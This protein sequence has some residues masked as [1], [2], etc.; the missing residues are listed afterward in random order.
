MFKIG[1]IGAGTITQK[2]ITAYQDNPL[3]EVVSI[4]DINPEQAQKTA[5]EF[6]IKNVYTHYH[7]ILNDESIDAVSIA[8]PTFTHKD[9]AI[10]AIKAHKHILC[11]KPPALNAD[12]AKEIQK[13]L[14]GYDKTFMFAF[15][16]RFD[17]KTRYI[18]EYIDSG[19]MGKVLSCEAIRYSQMAQ[20][21]GWFAKRELGGCSLIDGLFTNWI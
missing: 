10:D 16:R 3:C 14:E 12:E 6:G 8:T 4:A 1:I 21:K 15:V 11:E 17:N 18:K 2:H 7:D 9:I 20:S 5:N 19:K 13:A